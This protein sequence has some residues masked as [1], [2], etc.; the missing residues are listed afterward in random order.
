MKMP[1]WMKKTIIIL[2]WLIIWQICS[3]AADNDIILVGP[4]DTLSSLAMQIKELSF[5][6]TIV[7]SFMRITTGFLAAFLA[8]IL[9]AGF[10]YRFSL[11]GEFLD[12]LVQLMKSVPV[13]SFIILAL[14]W[15]GSKNLAVLVA[16][17][18][19]FPVLYIQ[20]LA[21]LKST[22]PKLLEMADVFHIRGFKKIYY[23]YQPA[24]LPYLTSACQSA[25]GM[26]WKSG[27]AA[28][29]IAVASLSIGEQLYLSKIYL[30][31][32]GLFAWTFVIILLSVLSEQLFLYLLLKLSR[33][34]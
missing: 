12:P 8:G 33:R 15:V 20:V 3:M 28:E 1:V 32:A 23:I 10:A 25:L 9:L 29:V 16:F 5:W 22:D 7:H 31:T 21:G 14:I 19:V 34:M 13:A 27:I 18:I 26:S 4:I 11:A 24:V 6:Q 30:D 17:L 2:F